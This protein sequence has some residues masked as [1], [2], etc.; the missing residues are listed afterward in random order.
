MPISQSIQNSL[1]GS[2]MIRKMFEEGLSLKAAHGAENVFDFSLGNPD[3]DPPA[4]FL[5]TLK[6]L[7]AK[8]AA[9]AHS[10][11]PNAGYFTTREAI[12]RKVSC[13]QGVSLGGGDIVMACGAAGALN[14]V[15]KTILNP[16]DEVIVSKPFFM[17]Y[18]HYA[19]NHG[20]RL[21]EIPAKPDFGLDVDAIEAALSAKTAAVLINFPNNPT[22]RI[23]SAETLAALSGA[24]LRHGAR[25]GRFPYL[26]ADEPYRELA[27][28]GRA[29][30][31]VLSAYPHAIVVSSF[32]KNLSLPGE[33][34][35]YIAAAPGID[36]KQNLLAGFIYATRILG[37]V[38]APALMQRALA[39]FFERQDALSRD[40]M[41][42]VYTS[43]RQAFMEVLNGAGITYIEPEGAFYIFARVPCG[44]NSVGDDALF[45]EHLKKHLIL[46]VPGSAFGA[47]GYA[48][49]AYC[50]QETAIRASAQ[51][52]KN[53]VKSW[54]VY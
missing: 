2:S 23:Y 18:R 1:A 25:S 32:S 13:D 3:R 34:I 10:Y 17:E 31:P 28:G 48:R 45:C 27:Y 7:T 19:H 42:E 39:A 4:A 11:M 15:F 26:I 49:F 33:R 9:G 29:V 46:A 30:P 47:P 35:G 21:V 53:A 6:A 51:A 37:F 16:G 12:A 20:G 14:V 8:P 40:D 22:G 44:K 54:A 24:L 43:R 50:V 36:D 38:N 52:F 41:L 5:E